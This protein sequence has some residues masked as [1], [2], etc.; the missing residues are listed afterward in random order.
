MNILDLQYDFKCDVTV[1][2]KEFGEESYAVTI[3]YMPE[4]HAGIPTRLTETHFLTQ[5]EYLALEDGLTSLL[6][7]MAMFRKENEDIR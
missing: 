1:G 5:N 7:K 6:H 2:E 3:E 4:Y